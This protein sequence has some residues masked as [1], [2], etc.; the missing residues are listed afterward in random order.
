MKL[1]KPIR[2]KEA[3]AI[4]NNY[5]KNNKGKTQQVYFEYQLLMDY[6]TS[7]TA[8]PRLKDP[9]KMGIKIYFGEYNA[10]FPGANMKDRIT[11]MLV[12]TIKV[13][14]VNQ[15]VLDDTKDTDQYLL[16]VLEAYN[17]GSLCPPFDSADGTYC[18][19]SEL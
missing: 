2:R 6:L 7:L 15:D 13:G 10:E 1:D 19:G 5:L 16:N 14:N 9:S 4:R 12:P 18:E 8:D 11:V 17:H 3:K